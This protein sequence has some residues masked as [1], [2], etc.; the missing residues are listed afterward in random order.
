MM[1]S[2]NNDFNK[3][4]PLQQSQQTTENPL[5]TI[6]NAATTLYANNNSKT[7]LMQSTTSVPEL[8]IETA[9]TSITG[10][11]SEESSGSSAE[12]SI[13]PPTYAALPTTKL[14][15]EP[16]PFEQSFKGAT[17][18]IKK[19]ILPSVN[20]MDSPINRLDELNNQWNSLRSGILS[21][22]ML[23]GPATETMNHNHNGVQQNN[24]PILPTKPIIKYES[25]ESSNNLNISPI[26][27]QNTIIVNNKRPKA[28]DSAS[29]STKKRTSK[30]VNGPE[31]EEKRRNFLERNRIAALKCRQRKKQ[32][33]QNLQAKVEYL[34]AD[35]EQLH[36][37]TNALK[38]ELIQ[39]KTLLMAHK[40]CPVN[41]SAV[42]AALNKPIPGITTTANA[43]HLLLHQHQESTNSNH[44]NNI[45]I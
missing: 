30:K 14:E 2:M 38:E 12:E 4:L 5:T 16:N 34:T 25:I 32:W 9:T 20:T 6:N 27:Y 24:I 21:P 3:L 39:L 41:Q 22:S 43:P 28:N 36:L 7:A 11:N 19:H 23:N 35:N 18:T 13:F 44:N 37:Q 42:Q 45:S 31:D 29:S 17:T 15:E 10:N 40:D 26:Q 33:L 8:L 1:T